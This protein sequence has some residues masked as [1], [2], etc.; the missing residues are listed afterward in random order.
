MGTI[1]LKILRKHTYSNIYKISPS[2]TENFLIKKLWYF[3]R[4][5]SWTDSVEPRFFNFTK[6]RLFKYEYAEKF[7]TKKGKYS[8]KKNPDLF[9]ISAQNIDC[10]YSLEP[11]WRSGSNKYPQSMFWAEIRKIVYTPANPSFTVRTWGLRGSKLYRHV[12]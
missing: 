8:D 10:G 9:H 11:P 3:F 12:L 7:R 2:K 4:C 1:F 5:I 6:I